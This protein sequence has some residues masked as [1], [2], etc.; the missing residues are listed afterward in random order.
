MPAGFR[1]EVGV[2]APAFAGEAMREAKSSSSIRA[3]EVLGPADEVAA[4][5]PRR[6]C[7][8]PCVEAMLVEEG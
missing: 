4:P 5:A 2:D 6:L 8:P 1:D 7:R 3:A